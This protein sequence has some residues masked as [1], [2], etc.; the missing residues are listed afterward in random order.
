MWLIWGRVVEEKRK[1]GKERVP[2]GGRCRRPWFV[3]CLLGSRVLG[4]LDV[5]GV[6]GV[7]AAA[8]LHVWASTSVLC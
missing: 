6:L 8:L 1:T 4:V 5:L 7:V 3:A 2:S